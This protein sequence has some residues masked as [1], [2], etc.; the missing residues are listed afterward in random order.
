MSFI[1]EIPIHKEGEVFGLCADAMLNVFELWKWPQFYDQSLPH[2]MSAPGNPDL[3]GNLT[4]LSFPMEDDMHVLPV[5]TDSRAPW[6][7]FNSNDFHVDLE[8]PGAQVGWL[9][10]PVV[11]RLREAVIEATLCVR[12]TLDGDGKIAADSARFIW[13]L[14][15]RLRSA[16]VRLE[17]IPMIHPRLANPAFDDSSHVLPLRG[18]LTGHL[19]LAE[20]LFRCGI[21]V[22]WVRPAH[23]LTTAT[24][25]MR[26]VNMIPASI[27]FNPK[28]LMKHGKY[29][30]VAP[31]WLHTSTFDNLSESIVQQL[32]HFSL[33][34][35][36]TLRKLAPVWQE[37]S[38]RSNDD[39]VTGQADDS[40][41]LAVGYPNVDDINHGGAAEDW[42]VEVEVAGVNIPCKSPVP[43]GSEL[44]RRGR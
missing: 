21:P 5:F 23:T 2:A 42:E 41:A 10:A 28:T 44:G 24:V 43:E 33:T 31:R 7:H 17:E 18:V 34:N 8:I 26:V 27:H 12:S 32:H 19:S 37:T 14:V 11:V 13:R 29:T 25:I 38:Q 40:P 30:H 4:H 15:Q 35:R 1:P 16:V 3:I 36:P 9:S 22:W 6:W 20:N 39:G